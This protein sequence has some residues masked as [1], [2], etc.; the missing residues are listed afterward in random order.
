MFVA[1]KEMF[2]AMSTSVKLIA[3]GINMRFK[4]RELPRPPNVVVTPLVNTPLAT[5]L[6]M[7]SKT[8]F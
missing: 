7:L 3:A 4:N 6:L 5:V 8:T 1:A 2:C